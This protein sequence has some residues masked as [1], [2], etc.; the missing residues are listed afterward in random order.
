MGEQGRLPYG[1]GWPN[2]L[3]L[4]SG[5]YVGDAGGV[6]AGTDLVGADQVGS[7]QDG[8]GFGSEG[9]IQALTDRRV[10]AVARKHFPTKDLRET[11]A[12]NG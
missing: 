8:Y 9:A 3:W 2:T 5:H 4:G 12:S 11:P 7:L 6:Y 1:S 10:G